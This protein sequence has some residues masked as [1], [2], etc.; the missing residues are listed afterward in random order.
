MPFF[1]VA[2]KYLSGENIMST[3]V[4]DQST[5]E[6][7][8]SVCLGAELRD[9]QGM[10]LGYFRPA[11]TPDNVDQ[12]ECPLSEEELQRRSQAGGGRPLADILSDLRSRS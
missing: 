1:L 7:F 4:L 9:E 3:L 6:K 2:R 12:C 5:A 11:I 8:K 10:L